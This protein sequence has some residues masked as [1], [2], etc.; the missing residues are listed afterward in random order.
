LGAKRGLWL[1][2][3]C[4]KREILIRVHGPGVEQGMLRIRTDHELRKLYK[5]LD[6]LADIKKKRL[7]WTGHVVRMDQGRTVKKIM[8]SK[9][10]SRRRERP[11]MRWLEDVEKDLREMKVK[12]WRQKAVDREE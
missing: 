1:R 9:P 12:R 6:V 4:T 11:R 7:E 2:R 8:E 10:K 5:E 3:T